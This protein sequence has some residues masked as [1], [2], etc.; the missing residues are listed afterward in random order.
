MSADQRE[1]TDR[2]G[3]NVAQLDR[4]WDGSDRVIG[5]A[6]GPAATSGMGSVWLFA[7]STRSKAAVL[8]LSVPPGRRTVWTG[9]TGSRS[10]WAGS[11][12]G[13]RSE[14]VC[15]TEPSGPIVERV[16]C[17]SA[18]SEGRRCFRWWRLHR[19]G[20]CAL[21][22]WGQASAGVRAVGL[23]RSADPVAAL[24]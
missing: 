20:P 7:P 14:R 9:A 4:L 11:G 15:P 1:A 2:S 13:T 23:R 21:S 22:P 6:P 19:G 3:L 24:G 18:S 10:R 8:E 12:I 5:F 16:L 17:Q